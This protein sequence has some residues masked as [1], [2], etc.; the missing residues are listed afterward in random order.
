MM[1]GGE[2][3]ARAKAHQPHPPPNENVACLESITLNLLTDLGS[4]FNAYVQK[5]L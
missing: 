5:H 2:V 1:E 3:S 4:F